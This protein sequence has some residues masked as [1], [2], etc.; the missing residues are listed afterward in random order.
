MTTTLYIIIAVEAVLL[1]AAAIYITYLIMRG[2]QAREMQQM[3][4]DLFDRQLDA[5]KAQMR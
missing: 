2:R 1:V 5:V 4:K 3:Q